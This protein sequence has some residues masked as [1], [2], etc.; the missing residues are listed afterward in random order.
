MK[1]TLIVFGSSTGNTETMAD[2][3][4]EALKKADMEA[5][6]KNVLNA[7][8]A[9]MTGEYDLVLLG[10]PAYG[11]EDVELQDD[12]PGTGGHKKTSGLVV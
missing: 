2:K 11:D 6:I 4:A 3:I 7:K 9:D 1:K 8:P 12:F 10:C 5:E